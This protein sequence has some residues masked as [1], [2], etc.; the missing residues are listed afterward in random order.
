MVGDGVVG[1]FERVACE[2]QDDSFARLHLA[3]LQKF[4]EA[5][6]RY[7]RGRLAANSLFA[8]FGFCQRNLGFAC[9]LAV[10]AGLLNDAYS[11]FP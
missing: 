4:F 2:Q 6:E 9:L 1:V 5:G 11:L 8:D 10:T 3:L 7:G